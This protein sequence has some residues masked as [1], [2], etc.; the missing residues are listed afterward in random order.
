MPSY[1]LSST[2]RIWV[3]SRRPWCL[4]MSSPLTLF[5]Q[6]SIND[7]SST[8]TLS[9]TNGVPLLVKPSLRALS[10]MAICLL[11]SWKCQALCSPL[12][13]SIYIVTC[14]FQFSTS[15]VR[16][17][18]TLDAPSSHVSTFHCQVVWKRTLSVTKL[19][20]IREKFGKWLLVE[21]SSM[22][23]VKWALEF[24]NTSA[25]FPIT[26]S[27]ASTLLLVQHNKADTLCV[28]RSCQIKVVSTNSVEYFTEDEVSTFLSRFFT[29][30]G[31]TSSLS[32]KWEFKSKICL[33]FHWSA[34]TTSAPYFQPL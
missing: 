20:K 27:I 16:E 17:S 21:K 24:F 29:I 26:K 32:Y 7:G 15:K 3:R 1:E 12:G 22:L 13:A 23:V 25:W 8:Q 28:V 14:L 5:T 18:Y 6:T 10:K 34:T 19:V 2:T 33:F 9:L 30:V 31:L 4:P 11:Y